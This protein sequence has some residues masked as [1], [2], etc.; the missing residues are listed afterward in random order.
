MCDGRGQAAGE[1]ALS[2]RNR[3]GLGRTIPPVVAR[4]VRQACG[5]G[6]VVCGSAL[7]DYD[8]HSPEFADATEHVASGIALL[9]PNDHRR[10]LKGLLTAETYAECRANPRAVSLGHASTTW[11]PGGR[12]P[13]V[14]VGCVKYK[15]G[16]SL[17]RIGNELVLGFEEPE[18]PGAPVRL[19]MKLR[20]R[21]GRPSVRIQENHITVLP[22]AFDV[23]ATGAVWTLRSAVGDVD[24]RIQF[25]LPDQISLTEL[26]LVHA[27]WSLDANSGS[28]SVK[29]DGRSRVSILGR[30]TIEGPCLFNCQPGG[31][32]RLNA[33]QRTGWD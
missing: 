32:V 23:E 12:L 27:L 26:T 14:V 2:R 4:Q 15:G 30:S 7:Y 31:L 33:S 8:H 28:L 3:H 11:T 16:T 17:L 19:T 20:D 22:D 1:G 21:T 10:K 18:S 25:E 13:E 6:C 24:A 5:F 29:Y 9:C